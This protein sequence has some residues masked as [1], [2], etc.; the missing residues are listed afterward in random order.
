MK[1]DYGRSISRAF[2]F[3]FSPKRWLPLLLL[4]LTLFMII[5][6]FILI[7]IPLIGAFFGGQPTSAMTMSVLGIVIP[8]VLVTVLWWLVAV[9]ITGAIIHQ[10]YK[11]NEYMKSWKLSFNRYLYLLAAMLLVAIITGLAGMI[12]YVGWV[13]SI[14]FGIMLFFT[15]QGVIITKLGPIES[16]KNSYEIFRKEPLDVFLVW[17]IALVI[18]LVIVGIFAIPAIIFFIGLLIPLISQSV[19]QAGVFSGLL[20]ASQPGLSILVASGILIVIGMSIAQAFSFK[21][22][23]EFYLQFKKKKLGLF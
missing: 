15:M 13:I 20:T 17:L 6:S 7:S 11:E 5:I 9:W 4:N 22:Q 8:L 19:T 18:S 12:P 2:N 16:L 3:G 10:T 1:L 14:I 23:T 21:L